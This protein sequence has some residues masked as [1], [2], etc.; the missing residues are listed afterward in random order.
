MDDPRLSMGSL[1]PTILG[2]AGLRDAAERGVTE[3]H[4][5]TDS[6]VVM[7]HLSQPHTCKAP[8]LKV[9]LAE[10][11]EQEARF[12][13]GVRFERITSKQNREADRL[14][15][16]GRDTSERARRFVWEPGDITI[17]RDEED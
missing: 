11:R 8:H 4:L 14:A 9:L 7:G 15:K 5:R 13:G 6:P 3:A 12:P 1:F 2:S 10:V 16:A 17:L